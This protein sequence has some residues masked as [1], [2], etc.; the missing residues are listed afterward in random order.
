MVRDHKLE[1]VLHRDGRQERAAWE[2]RGAVFER[3]GAPGVVQ[4]QKPSVGH[5][6]GDALHERDVAR[7]LGRDDERLQGKE[8]ESD[9]EG[10]RA[11]LRLD[12]RPRRRRESDGSGVCLNDSVKLGHSSARC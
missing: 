10:E 6:H 5:Q 2:E 7:E 1:L 3:P 11:A 9:S 4:D 8:G 12:E